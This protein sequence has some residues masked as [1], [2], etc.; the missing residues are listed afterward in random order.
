MGLIEAP[1]KEKPRQLEAGDDEGED[2]DNVQDAE[3]EMAD[4][5]DES[6]PE[7][8]LLSEFEELEEKAES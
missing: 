2:H 8:Q 5:D 3:V 4:E 7:A 6:I 1:A